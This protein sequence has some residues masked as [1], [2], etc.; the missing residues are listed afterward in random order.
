VGKL[1]FSPK[2]RTDRRVIAGLSVLATS[3]L[4]VIAGIRGNPLG[5]LPLVIAVAL[6]FV[7]MGYR[8]EWTGFG[9]STYVKPENEEIRPKKTLWDWMSLLFVPLM[10]AAVGY[11][12]MWSQN[13]SQQAIQAQNTAIQTYLNQMHTLIVDEDLLSS[14][15]VDDPEKT[16]ARNVARARTLTVLRGLGPD[17]KRAVLLFLHDSGLIANDEQVIKLDGADLREANLGGANL[18]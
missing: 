7:Y 4:A 1:L 15:G 10:L 6:I 12:F 11:W 14:S 5:Y 16:S 18:K 13:N 9:E 17:G 2:W 3:I 8:R